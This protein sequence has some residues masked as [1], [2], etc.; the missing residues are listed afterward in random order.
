MTTTTKETTVKTEIPSEFC[1]C[2]GRA[3][4]MSNSD[5]GYS[6]CCNDRIT[7]DPQ[8]HPDNYEGE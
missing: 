6:H 1:M 5:E 3:A 4:S 8:E 2:C 7:S